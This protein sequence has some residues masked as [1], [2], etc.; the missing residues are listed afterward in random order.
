MKAMD[1]MKDI[2]QLQQ[3]KK[4]NVESPFCSRCT[5]SPPHSFSVISSIFD[6]M[7]VHFSRVKCSNVFQQTSYHLS[8]QLPLYCAQMRKRVP[9]AA[10]KSPR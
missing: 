9:L 6:S 1:V 3:L 4:K 2:H 5:D 10:L 7:V 8:N